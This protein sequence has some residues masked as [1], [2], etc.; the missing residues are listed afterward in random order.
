[1]EG[2]EK[3]EE[4]AE[5]GLNLE[6]AGFELTWVGI[7]EGTGCPNREGAASTMPRLS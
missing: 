7:G 4:S 3:R 5:C 1:M 2:L 6:R